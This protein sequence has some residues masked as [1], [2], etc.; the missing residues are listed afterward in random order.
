MTSLC[1]D[2]EQRTLGHCAGPQHHAEGDEH[3]HDFEADGTALDDPR[4]L[5]RSRLALIFGLTR[6]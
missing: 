3:A 4:V 5:L 6:E 1:H 2:E